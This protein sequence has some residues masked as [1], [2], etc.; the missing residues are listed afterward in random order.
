MTTTAIWKN[1]KKMGLTLKKPRPIHHKAD[2]KE[3]ETFKKKIRD[4]VHDFLKESNRIVFFF[5]EG[6]FG[7]Q[8]TVMRVW[9]EKGKPLEIK[10]KQGYKNFY[11]Y[12]SVSPHTGDSFSLFMPEVNT[13]MMNVYL[14]E[15]QKSFPDKKLMLIMDQAAWH[16]SDM[17]LEFENI[18]LKFLSPYSPELNPIEK[19]WWWLRKERTH[20]KVFKTIDAMMDSLEIEFRNLTPDILS[21]LC[22]CKYL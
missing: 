16:K 8:S 11:I 1:L 18:Q 13:E 21:S 20:N 9:A 7:L 19:L 12:S 22:R 10:V 17:L 3:Q 15:L 6:R 5:D 4:E 14:K 2:K